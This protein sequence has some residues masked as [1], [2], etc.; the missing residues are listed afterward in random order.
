MNR[1][2]KRDIGSEFRNL[3]LR[4][5]REL[6]LLYMQA[7]RSVWNHRRERERARILKEKRRAFTAQMGR[8]GAPD[9]APILVAV[10]DEAPVAATAKPKAK[11]A[12]KTNGAE[13][14]AEAAA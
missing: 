2:H 3:L 12:R 8:E 13:A 6:H 11:R 4:F 7:K 5:A 10:S 1:I 14:H 9:E